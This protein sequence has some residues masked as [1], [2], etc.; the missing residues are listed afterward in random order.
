MVL[1]GCVA[2]TVPNIL[3][4]EVSRIFFVPKHKQ[5]ELGKRMI[6]EIVTKLR[7]SLGLKYEEY[8]NNL[9]SGFSQRYMGKKY[10]SPK[11]NAF[12]NLL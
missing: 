9:F 4:R 3:C 12:L 11:N 8:G 5:V 1:L 2:Y 7:K 10:S 6:N